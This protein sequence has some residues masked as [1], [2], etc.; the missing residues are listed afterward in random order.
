MYDGSRTSS[1]ITTTDFDVVTGVLENAEETGKR[2]KLQN[3]N[4]SGINL[5]D[6]SYIVRKQIS[7][8]VTGSTF[9]FPI[10]DLGD[11]DL[12]F[13]PFTQTNY[14]LT[15]ATGNKE[16]LTANQVTISSNLKEIEITNL[17]QTG[18]STL[19]VTCKRSKLKSKTKTIDRCKVFTIVNSKLNGAGI[20]T[21]TFNDGLTFSDVYGRR[22]QDDEIALPFPEAY[23]VLGVFE[24]NDNADA[25]LPTVTVS[26][27]ETAH[28]LIM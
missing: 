8:N 10:S 25:D 5:L 13:E 16:T 1:T 18:N 2:I 12:F 24:S 28:L 20:G 14:I 4:V 7:K 19:T 21:T 11:D 23:R 15:W 6:S 3:L 26:T 17:S 9:T 27:Q 22:V